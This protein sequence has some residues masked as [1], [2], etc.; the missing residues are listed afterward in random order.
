M[1]R[2]IKNVYLSG[3]LGNQLFQY[4]IFK[5]ILNENFECLYLDHKI[6]KLE[7]QP[8]VSSNIKTVSFKNLPIAVQFNFYVA[9]ILSI[10]GKRI[11]SGKYG[12]S[13]LF[14]SN[15]DFR[16]EQVG[17][18]LPLSHNLGYF[19][20]RHII[21]DK[22]DEIR[23]HFLNKIVP[24]YDIDI[25]PKQLDIAI[26]MR[27]GDDYSKSHDLAVCDEEYYKRSLFN[28]I[29]SSV[30]DNAMPDIYVFSDNPSKAKE[31]MT[32]FGIVPKIV[33]I[34]EAI[35]SLY[36]L[37]RF[38]RFILSNSSF[39]WW[40]MFLS[41]CTYSDVIAPKNWTNSTGHDLLH[42]DFKHV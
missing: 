10:F 39:S 30:A 32:K 42:P 17:D 15:V 4:Y 3:G 31:L 6:R 26:S 36:C 14:G 28:L 38:N 33:E 13:S 23:E 5:I 12:K 41:E 34:P 21:E 1:E 9:K 16:R 25:M 20:F 22:R 37:S 18:L 27:L 11:H 24:L 2:N 35:H 7:I 19:Q 40:G 8:L 29:G